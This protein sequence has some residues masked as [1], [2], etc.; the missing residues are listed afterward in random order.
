MSSAEVDEPIEAPFGDRLISVSKEPCSSRD[1]H[2]RHLANA[3]ERSMLGGDASLCQF[4]LLNA[5]N[6]L[7]NNK[8]AHLDFLHKSALAI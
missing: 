3:I 8:R 2:C 5:M 6:I 7:F 4:T 1:A